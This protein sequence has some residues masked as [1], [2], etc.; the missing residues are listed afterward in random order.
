MTT[1]QTAEQI[2]LPQ[3]GTLK[4]YARIGNKGNRGGHHDWISRDYEDIDCEA[5]GCMFNIGKKCAVPTRCEIGADGRCKGF[6][7]KPLGKVDGD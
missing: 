6:Q 5:T 2:N 3:T 1:L 4:L 7:A